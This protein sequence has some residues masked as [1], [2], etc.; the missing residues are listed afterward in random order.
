MYVYLLWDHGRQSLLAWNS[1]VLP[2][3]HQ[4]DLG[5]ESEDNL[6]QPIVAVTPAG[7]GKKRARSSATP[8]DDTL[9][10]HSLDLLAKI[11]SSAP[12]TQSTTILSTGPAPAPH[13]ATTQ[14]LSSLS[15]QADLLTAKLESL[16]LVLASLKPHLIKS[17]EAIIIKMCKLTSDGDDALVQQEVLM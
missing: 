16:P 15:A 11:H 9:L 1:I 3:E 12:T 8:T 2:E 17:L 5:A 4:F 13:V 7:K 6:G 14:E 10:A